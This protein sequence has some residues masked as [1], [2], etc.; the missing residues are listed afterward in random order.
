MSIVSLG[1]YFDA[2]MT[3]FY[4]AQVRGYLADDRVE[5]LMIQTFDAPDLNQTMVD[6]HF[7]NFTPLWNFFMQDLGTAIR[8]YG[9]VF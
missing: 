4:E 9:H 7:T 8:N 2:A 3:V 5:K 1:R 6:T